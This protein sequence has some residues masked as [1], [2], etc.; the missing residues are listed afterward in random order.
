MANNLADYVSSLTPL[1]RGLVV[2]CCQVCSSPSASYAL[3][4]SPC[5]PPSK[6]STTPWQIMN[7]CLLMRI[8]S[9]LIECFPSQMKMELWKNWAFW[10]RRTE[11]SF[12]FILQGSV[13][14]PSPCSNS[15]CNQKKKQKTYFVFLLWLLPKT[16][17]TRCRTWRGLN[18]EGLFWWLHSTMSH[19]SELKPQPGF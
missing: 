8:V 1:V 13:S 10:T 19:Q 18:R 12:A 3:P 9:H 17:R 11:V 4:P 14:F 2:A 15:F 16:Q 7:L 6:I 5:S